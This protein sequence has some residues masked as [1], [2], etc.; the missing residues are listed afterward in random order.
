[1]HAHLQ[2]L[3]IALASST[4]NALVGLSVGLSG[5]TL[6]RT[7]QWGI[8]LCNAVG[9]ACATLG[10]GILADYLPGTGLAALAFAYLAWQEYNDT[11][12]HTSNAPPPTTASLQ[13][14]IPMT[15]NNVAGGVTGGALGI[16]ATIN[17][18]YSMGVSVVT[19]WVGYRLGRAWSTTTG[20][21]PVLSSRHASH[22]S[23]VLFTLLS[24]H[25]LHS[26]VSTSA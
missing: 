22:A 1:M 23:V 19:M 17:F 6:S 3:W 5:K 21:T 8:A 25:S 16:S 11:T 12:T 18:G 7:V 15:L 26:Y 2:A 10:G 9:C 20:S 14:A 24:L 13:L 4:D